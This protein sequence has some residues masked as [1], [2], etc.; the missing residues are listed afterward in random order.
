MCTWYASLQP[1]NEVAASKWDHHLGATCLMGIA[2]LMCAPSWPGQRWTSSISSMQGSKRPCPDSVKLLIPPT[3]GEG[4]NGHD[5]LQ[6]LELCRGG[7][8]FD[9]IIEQGTFTERKAA[10]E[11][12][13]SHYGPTQYIQNG[14]KY[15]CQIFRVHPSLS[16]SLAIQ[17]V[18]G[19]TIRQQHE[20]IG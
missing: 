5:D 20:C 14:M 18:V 17:A 10:G 11:Q 9:R 4:E 12:F 1:P 13:A 15:D 19:H 2:P 16:G 3:P 7:E 8:L 6:I